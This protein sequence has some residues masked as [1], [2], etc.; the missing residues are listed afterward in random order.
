MDCCCTSMQ[1]WEE[2]EG[3]IIYDVLGGNKVRKKVLVLSLPT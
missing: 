3:G 2:V 1:T